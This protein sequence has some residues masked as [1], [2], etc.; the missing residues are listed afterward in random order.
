MLIFYG[1]TPVLQ[2]YD[3]ARSIAWYSDVLGF[4]ADPFPAEP[5]F[6]FAILARDRAEVMLQ[7]ARP[8]G[9]SDAPGL[10]PA[11]PSPGWSVYLRL[12]GGNLLGFAEEIRAKA[13]ILRGPERM[14]YGHVEFEVADP[15]GHRIRVSELLP[16]GT[17]AP[18]ARED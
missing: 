2:V 12:R 16:P 17:D 18:M 13:T 15:D 3:V 5:P 1:A 6:A 14:A 8:A 10:A 11:G 4:Q 7:R 9:L